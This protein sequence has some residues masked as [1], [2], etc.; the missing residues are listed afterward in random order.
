MIIYGEWLPVRRLENSE[1]E[2][3]EQQAIPS[4]LITSSRGVRKAMSFILI[5]EGPIWNPNQGWKL[6][7]QPQ[8]TIP[9]LN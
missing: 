2:G 6:S 9:E 4:A 8:P 7:P 1:E 5:Y 3:S